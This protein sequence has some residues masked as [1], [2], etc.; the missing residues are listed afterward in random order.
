V[1][2]VSVFETKEM[3]LGEMQLRGRG[4]LRKMVWAYPNDELD[5]F[6]PLLA[7]RASRVSVDFARGLLLWDGTSNPSETVNCAPRQSLK[8]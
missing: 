7:L 2:P 4:V 6:L 8:P 5:G 1:T 3:T